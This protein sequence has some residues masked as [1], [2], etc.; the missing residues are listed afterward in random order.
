M[1]IFLAGQPSE[2]Q[3]R[4]ES[5]ISNCKALYKLERGLDFSIEVRIGEKD[6]VQ[7]KKRPNHAEY[8]SYCT[9][10]FNGD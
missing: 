1:A 4:A 8:V 6:P 7:G 5:I 3:R 2:V 10:F 9:M